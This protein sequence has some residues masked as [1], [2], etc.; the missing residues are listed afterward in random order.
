MDRV[1]IRRRF[2]ARAERRLQRARTKPVCQKYRRVCKKKKSI[3]DI[4]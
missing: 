4:Y 1:P 3:F 2:E